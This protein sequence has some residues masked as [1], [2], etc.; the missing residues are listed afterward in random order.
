MK[1][2]VCP[3][4]L[5]PA[6]RSSLRGRAFSGIPCQLA[7]SRVYHVPPRRTTHEPTAVGHARRDLIAS[8]TVSLG[9]RPGYNFEVLWYEAGRP[10]YGRILFLRS[11]RIRSKTAVESNYV[12]ASYVNLTMSQFNA[13]VRL[14]YNVGATITL[15]VLRKGRRL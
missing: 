6:V 2:A 15:D 10:G 11:R 13:H 12:T 4:I 3:K 5:S 7:F 1:N 8:R 14:T 9:V